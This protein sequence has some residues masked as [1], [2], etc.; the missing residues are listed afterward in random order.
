[1]VGVFVFASAVS[2][3]AV[4]TIVISDGKKKHTV[5][6]SDAAGLISF[7]GTV[8][9]FTLSLSTSAA[10]GEA[11]LPSLSLNSLTSSSRKAGTLTISISNTSLVGSGIA[12][13]ISGQTSGNVM[14]STHADAGNSLFGRSTLLNSQGAFTGGKFANT[15]QAAFSS[16]S[17]FSLTE[18]FVIQQSK[19]G[20][21]SFGSTVNDPIVNGFTVPV[22]ETGSTM[23]LL[24]LALLG[25]EVIRRKLTAA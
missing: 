21:T 22:P 14:V 23:A 5:T 1:V 24:G 18:T 3:L 10:T 7:N 4:P 16:Q 8:G 6:L 25:V 12:S 20:T 15:A 2:A 17:P 13:Q 19:K 9:K 11:M